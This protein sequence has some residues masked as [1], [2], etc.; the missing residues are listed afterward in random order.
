MMYLYLLSIQML[1]VSLRTFISAGTER[2]R[3]EV[4]PVCPLPY[5]SVACWV[6]N[7]SGTLVP[8]IRKLNCI[9]T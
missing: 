2:T 6:D 5:R 7:T 1:S 4:Y 3:P 8:S 9:G